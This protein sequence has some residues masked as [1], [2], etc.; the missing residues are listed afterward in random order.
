MS[1]LKEKLFGK[2]P[3]ISS[4]HFGDSDELKDS[5]HEYNQMQLWNFVSQGQRL[6]VQIN[7]YELRSVERYVIYRI[8]V[9]AL[10]QEYAIDRRYSEFRELHEYYSRFMPEYDNPS[11]PGT[12]LV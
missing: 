3:R 8:S 9:S 4:C 7:G 2:K 12:L 5:S 6:E 11:F 1:W 10:G